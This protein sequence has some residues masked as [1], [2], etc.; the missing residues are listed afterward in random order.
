MDPVGH[1][2]ICKTMTKFYLDNVISKHLENV[3]SKHVEPA[4]V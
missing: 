4:V 3:I 2:I 1:W